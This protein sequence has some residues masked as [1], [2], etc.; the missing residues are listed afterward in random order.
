MPTRT[1]RAGSGH[2]HCAAPG[3]GI[4]NHRLNSDAIVQDTRMASRLLW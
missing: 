4:L 3:V 1:M 2:Y